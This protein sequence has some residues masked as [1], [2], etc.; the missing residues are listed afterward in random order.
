M[1]IVHYISR[2]LRYIASTHMFTQ[3][4]K[5]TDTFNNLYSISYCLYIFSNTYEIASLKNT[6]NVKVVQ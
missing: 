5:N 4:Y 1:V 2:E 6:E 3:H